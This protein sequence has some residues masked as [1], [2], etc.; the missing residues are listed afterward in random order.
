MPIPIVGEGL[1]ILVVADDPHVLEEKLAFPT[2]VPHADSL[3]AAV[4]IVGA[5]VA[6]AFVS[7]ENCGV[8]G[9]LGGGAFRLKALMVDTAGCDG[10]EAD[11]EE[12][13]NR[14]SN[15]DEVVGFEYNVCFWI[16]VEVPK[17]PPVDV[18]D[19]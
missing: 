15:A 16:C 1:L 12:K 9:C 8:V 6:H 13:S 19:N 14:S 18:G 5:G 4:E 11:P 10:A 7:N 17:N 3:F 2:D